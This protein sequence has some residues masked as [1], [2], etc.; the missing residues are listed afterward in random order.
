MVPAVCSGDRAEFMMFCCFVVVGSLVYIGRSAGLKNLVVSKL[1]Q[2]ALLFE[3]LCCVEIT[4]CCEQSL[5]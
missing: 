1:S 2:V 5:L 4:L 3:H